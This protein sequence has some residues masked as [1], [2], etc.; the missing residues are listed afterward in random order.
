MAETLEIRFSLSSSI[1][2]YCVSVLGT[3][4]RGSLRSSHVFS[5]PV[6]PWTC[7]VVSQIPLYVW[8]IFSVL[9]LRCL[10][11]KGSKREK[12]E[13]NTIGAAP[14]NALE[15]TST[16]GDWNNGGRHSSEQ[17]SGHHTEAW[18]R[19]TR[20]SLTILAPA[21][22]TRNTGAA[23]CHG[24]GGGQ[25]QMMGT[26]HDFPAKPSPGSCR[27]SNRLHSSKTAPLDS[28]CQF[29]CCPGGDGFLVLQ[30]WHHTLYKIFIIISKSNFDF[31]F[32]KCLE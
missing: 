3:N 5:E 16:T 26:N 4:L 29:K 14:V 6:V 20:F 31:D 22:C 13:K 25:T 2:C 27:P 1:C 17:N 12:K 18:L 28:F 10:V 7:A 15:A 19:I 32:L 11:P 8:L 9:L 24:L 23:V 30:P 21:S